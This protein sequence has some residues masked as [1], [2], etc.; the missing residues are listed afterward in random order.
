MEALTVLAPKRE[1]GFRRGAVNHS[2]RNRDEDLIVK[3]PRVEMVADEHLIE[4]DR[5]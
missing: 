1:R 2:L 4:A 3:V 5:Q